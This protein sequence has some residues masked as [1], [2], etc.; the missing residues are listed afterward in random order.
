MHVNTTRAGIIMKLMGN[1][2]WLPCLARKTCVRKHRVTELL[3]KK[4]MWNLVVLF[5]TTHLVKAI[6]GK[7]RN[8]KFCSRHEE[9]A[10]V[11]APNGFRFVKFLSPSRE[12]SLHVIKRPSSHVSHPTPPFSIP[13]WTLKPS[14]KGRSR[15]CGNR[16]MLQPGPSISA[17]S[18]CNRLFATAN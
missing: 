15:F 5:D 7:D 17:W 8:D 13:L 16:L 4:L 14:V 10:K 3:N 9:K 2:I 1:C 11:S 12:P 6:T 18:R